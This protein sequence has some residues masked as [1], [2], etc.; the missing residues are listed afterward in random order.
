MSRRAKGLLT[1]RRFE[2]FFGLDGPLELHAG[3]RLFG[4][5]FLE[6]RLRGSQLGFHAFHAFLKFRHAREKLF[7]LGFQGGDLE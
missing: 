6:G 4:L 1:V 2:G 3:L 7:V 5:S